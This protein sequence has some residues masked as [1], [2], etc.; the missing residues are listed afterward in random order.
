MEKM[1]KCV[2]SLQATAFLKCLWGK[3][4]DLTGNKSTY[5]PHLL[6]G[7]YLGTGNAAVGTHWNRRPRQKGICVMTT[8]SKKVANLHP[9]SWDKV[10]A[11]DSHHGSRWLLVLPKGWPRNQGNVNTGTNLCWGWAVPSAQGREGGVELGLACAPQEI[12][13]C[14]NSSPEPLDPTGG[15]SNNQELT[16]RFWYHAPGRM[17]RDRSEKG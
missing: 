4:I 16:Q 10:R 2:L 3:K 6:A 17:L 13:Q 14:V 8:S 15:I 5:R 1:Q 12:L 9:T 11:S 7:T